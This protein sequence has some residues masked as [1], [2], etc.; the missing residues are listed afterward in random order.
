MVWTLDYLK[1]STTV[2]FIQQ[3][4]GS[5]YCKAFFHRMNQTDGNF[6]VSEIGFPYFN[7]DPYYFYSKNI[8]N[9]PVFCHFPAR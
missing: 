2:C 6:E 7:Q 4:S 8:E 5:I 1:V 3:S 9:N